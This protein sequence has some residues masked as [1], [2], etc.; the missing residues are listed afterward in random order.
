MQ[1]N[2]IFCLIVLVDLVCTL[3]FFNN[4]FF[5]LGLGVWYD[6]LVEDSSDERCVRN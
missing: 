4:M 6:R 2:E 1:R 3:L 5:R